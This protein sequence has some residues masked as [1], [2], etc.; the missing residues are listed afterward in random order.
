MAKAAGELLCAEINRFRP[1]IHVITRR[2]PR[3]L[4]DQTVSLIQRNSEDALAV[5]LPIVR[6]M[7][8]TI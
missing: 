2:L 3:V 1:G 4:T 8:L 6:M 7:Q 5:M